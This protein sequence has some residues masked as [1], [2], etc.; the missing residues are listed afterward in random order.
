MEPTRITAARTGAALALSLT[1]VL[2]WLSARALASDRR[3]SNEAGVALLGTRVLVS[4]GML[5]DPDASRVAAAMSAAYDRMRADEEDPRSPV[6]L[7]PAPFSPQTPELLTYEPRTKG[8]V[9]GDL[10]VIFLHG[11]GGR[12]ALPCWQVARAA[13]QSSAV[14]ACPDVGTDGAWWSAE[15]ERI[16]RD[17]VVALQGAGAKRIVLMGLSNG[18]IGATRL[19][20]RMKGAFVGLVLLSGADPNVGA[21][22][23]PTLV[24]HG[25]R[26]AMVSQESSRIYAT[27]AHASFVDLP[28]GHF[29]M[30]LDAATVDPEIARFLRALHQ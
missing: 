2:F 6:V 30:L 14:T 3:P 8:D 20:A 11:Y 1:L 27:R 13:A 12:F 21:A 28:S 9:R 19:S 22:G 4:N 5:R 29:A 10:A 26:D 23:V 18:G 16:V 15:G 24:M 7:G 25:R 17:T